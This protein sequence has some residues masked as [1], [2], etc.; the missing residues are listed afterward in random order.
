VAQKL[1]S[2]LSHDEESVQVRNEICKRT[3][4]MREPSKGIEWRFALVENEG[5]DSKADWIEGVENVEQ[6]ALP[7]RVR[8]EMKGVVP[9]ECYIKTLGEGFFTPL[10][11]GTAKTFLL[12]TL[13]QINSAAET[14]KQAG[15]R[16]HCKVIGFETGGRSISATQGNVQQVR[17]AQNVTKKH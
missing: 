6:P 16:V 11:P 3:R 2:R 4:C 5:F 14:S 15:C 9:K 1:G 10:T 7:Q 17:P 13:T 8:I 12:A